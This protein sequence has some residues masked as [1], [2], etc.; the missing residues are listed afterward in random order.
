M[1]LSA[2]SIFTELDDHLISLSKVM[3]ERVEVCH[4]DKEKEANKV[5]RPGSTSNSFDSWTGIFLPR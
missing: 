1:H 4:E 3:N 2:V 5:L